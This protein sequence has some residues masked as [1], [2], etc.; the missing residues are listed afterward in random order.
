VADHRGMIKLKE[1]MSSPDR[2][3]MCQ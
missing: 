1:G 2:S 3:E